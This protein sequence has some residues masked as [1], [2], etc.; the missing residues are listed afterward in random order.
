M[1]PYENETNTGYGARTRM[2]NPNTCK[3][4]IYNMSD[5]FDYI[6]EEKYQFPIPQSLLPD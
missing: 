1:K 5:F 6:T 3:T 2:I 4:Y